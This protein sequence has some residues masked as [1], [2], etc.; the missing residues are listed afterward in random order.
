M[1]LDPS[2]LSPAAA[3]AI[4][5]GLLALAGLVAVLVA[6][7]R[8]GPGSARL[9]GVFAATAALAGAARVLESVGAGVSALAVASAAALAWYGAVA[10]WRSV[11]TGDAPA[12]LFDAALAACRDGVVIVATDARAGVRI[13]YANP[14]FE[15]L[16]GYSNEEAMGL[17]PSVLVDEGDSLAAVR[18][19]L[20]GAE[21]VRAEVPG[22][23]KD[24]RRVWAEWQIVPVTDAGG[25]HT[26][27][28]AV[29]RDITERR[30][31]ER[32]LRESEAR[33][34]GLFE[35]AADAILVL[36]R[37]GRIVDANHQACHTLGYTRDELTA[38]DAST[39]E[40][41]DGA[42]GGGTGETM[43]AESA[44]RRKDGTTFVAEVRYAV[45]AAAGGQVSLA[46]FR[47]V[48]RRRRAEQA[49]REREE[50]LRD[51]IAHIPCG[52]FW[53]DRSSVYLGCNE[54]VARDHG[55]ADP[56]QVV[57]R[58]DYDISSQSEEA[59]FY[60]DCDAQVI[61]SGRPILDLEEHMTRPDGT[62]AALLTSKVPLLDARG[63]VVGILGVYTDITDRKRLEEQFR[64]AQKLEA[65]G[66]LAGGVAHDFNNLLT[67]IRGNA[68]LLAPSFKGADAALLD[69]LILASDRA[70]ALVRQLLVFSR[71]Q[72]AR[73]EV[74]DLNEVVGALS[75][76]LR[77]L[78]GARV[79]VE[80]V[81]ADAPVTVRADRSHLEQVVMNL[82]VNARD[83]M[84]G[85]GTLT[86]R[87]GT[88]EGPPGRL[89]RL[90]VSDTGTG[91][92]DEVR[93]RIF[94]PFFTTKGPDKGTGLGLATV[95]GIVQQSGGTI[96]VESAPGAGTTFR[97][98]LP[99]V[100]GR[101]SGLIVTPAPRSGERRAR[102]VSVLL[103]EDQDAVRKFARMALEGQGHEVVEAD[104]G[105][106]ALELVRAG[107]RFDALVSDVV[108]PGIDGR[109]LAARVRARRPGVGVV[110]MS[111]YA[112][113]SDQIEPL[114]GAVFLPKPFP[115]ADLFSAL[116]KALRQV[117]RSR[118]PVLGQWSDQPLV[119]GPTRL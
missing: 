38:L 25:R 102:R 37:G 65:V 42:P 14:A 4:T 13:V 95:F 68:E 9:V 30:R 112:P 40:W 64:Q 103:V 10:L 73:V 91:M 20:L 82:A 48:T 119:A 104:S 36:D 79:A 27:S 76:L 58:T 83:A 66:R 81:V 62:R 84:P 47:D 98:D 12:P 92:T 97:V 52:V 86:V 29:L 51:V 46:M 61:E 111:G 67:V 55:L 113:D 56:E 43:T 39:L 54:R 72:P 118:D 21:P 75:G 71:R 50:L 117:G 110:L 101:A 7:G 59:Q 35:Q 78:L 26:H 94:E 100:P 115:P 2:P 6:F 44:Y 31:A 11:P 96:E 53:K 28:I 90:T 24:G 5:G 77:R 57:G 3:S 19:A 74:L 1:P 114:E 87:T 93:A 89:A 116:Q 80:I 88:A 69:D 17:S 16:T 32:A 8:R 34:R 85:G 70:T 41:K 18:G 63:E 45:I 107:T 106:A 60:R 15:H 23:R 99:W 33:F 105:E 108:M 109:E 22:R 49:L